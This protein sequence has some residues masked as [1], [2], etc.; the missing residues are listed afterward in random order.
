[1]ARYRSGGLMKTALVGLVA[2]LAI[3]LVLS[4][5]AVSYSEE[6]IV[7]KDLS[8]ALTT[9]AKLYFYWNGSYGFESAQVLYTD[10]NPDFVTLSAPDYTN[11]TTVDNQTVTRI[12]YRYEYQIETGYT[13]HEV[14]SKGI[15]KLIIAVSVTVA[16]KTDTDAFTS[17]EIGLFYPDEEGTSG[18]Y[19]RLATIDDQDCDFD[20]LEFVVDPSLIAAWAASNGLDDEHVWIYITAG[21]DVD[22]S[23]IKLHFKLNV[24]SKKSLWQVVYEP[25][26]ALVGGF[27]GAVVAAIRKIEDWILGAISGGGLGALFTGL[28]ENQVAALVFTLIILG[29]IFYFVWERPRPRRSSRRRRRRR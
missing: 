10:A 19:Y 20:E 7:T 26:A 13:F 11:T 17:L 18:K 2:I 28:F 14:V 8:Q 12:A 5:V 3:Y 1:M 27:V 22:I 4:G 21:K 9:R 29:V 24:V 6:Y 16:N 25:V 15:N 23:A